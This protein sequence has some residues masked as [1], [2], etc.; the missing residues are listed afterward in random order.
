VKG[1]PIERTCLYVILILMAFCIVFP[2]YWMLVTA[3]Q[4][5]GQAT[6]YP[7]QFFPRMFSVEGM[8]RVF[9]TLPIGLWIRNS[10]VVSSATSLLSLVIAVPAAYSIARY[11][12]RFNGF[13]LFSVL[14]TQMIP[15]A[16]LVVPLYEMFARFGLI[17]N[18]IALVL[19]NCILILPLATWIMVGFFEKIPHE[20]EESAVIDGASRMILFTHINLPLTY[21]AL[22]T[23]LILNFFDI[24][25]EYMYAYT[26]IIDQ[27]KWMGTV[28]LASLQGQ[29]IT[30]WQAI[31]NASVLYC[32]PPLLIYLLLRKYIVR[33]I[34]EGFGK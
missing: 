5:V 2:V 17:D 34:A 13:I 20:L 19:A 26:F 24:W 8:K 11:K 21:P 28:G 7:P 18:L 16:I 10:L 14:V 29:F 32:I 4:P 31:M 12:N 23:I 9:Q 15:P 33:G 3:F 30:D 1:R 27:N 25:N 22:V 6:A